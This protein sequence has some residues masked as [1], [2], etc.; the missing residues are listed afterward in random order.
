MLTS[1]FKKAFCLLQGEANVKPAIRK[2]E[3]CPGNARMRKHP[4]FGPV[5]ASLFFGR[6]G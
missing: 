5:T 1:L 2:K 3:V 6:G 4:I